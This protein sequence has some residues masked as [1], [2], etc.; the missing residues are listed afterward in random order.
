M[1]IYNT[2]RD[3]NKNIRDEIREQNHKLKNA[4][5][6]DK[7]RYFMDY[8]S[9]ITFVIIIGIAII[10]YIAYS[11]FTSP[12]NTVFAAYFFNSN[13]N[14]ANTSLQDDFLKHLEINTNDDL[15]YIDTTIY[16]D[17]ENVTKDITANINK[18]MIEMYNGKLDII[19]GDSKTIDYF[20]YGEY[21][22]DITEVLPDDLLEQFKDRL[23]YAVINEEGD[24]IPVGIYITDS[25]QLKK[26][27]YYENSEAILGFIL[28]S[29]NMDNAIE[30][31][32]YLYY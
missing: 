20:S 19:V 5:F 2:H 10:I 24:K 11:I 6:K 28:N 30:F 12:K 17:N 13:S 14:P 3:N 18:T 9:K 21:F 29:K 1:E 16:F 31:I 26:Y 23:Y 4:S 8:Y 27:S 22:H 25:P 15:A 7:F 32:R